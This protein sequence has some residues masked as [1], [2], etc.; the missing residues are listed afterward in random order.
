LPAVSWART[1]AR[2]ELISGYAIFGNDLGATTCKQTLFHQQTLNT[3]D[4]E[5]VNIDFPATVDGANIGPLQAMGNSTIGG[6]AAAGSASANVLPFGP[7]D[8]AFPDISETVSQSYG[9]SITGF[10]TAT[11]LSIPP[12]N[13]GGAP[14]IA[15]AF[16]SGAPLDMPS[17]L[18]GSNMMFPEMENIIP[19]FDQTK[20]LK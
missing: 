6:I 3:A 11:F 8:L 15:G 14:V 17:S 1:E 10:Y 2:Y 16:A 13:N 7:V 20:S 18:V 4:L 19:G 12:I 9:E 5:S